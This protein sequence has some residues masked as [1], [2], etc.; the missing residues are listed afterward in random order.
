[1]FIFTVILAMSNSQDWPDAFFWITMISVVVINSKYFTPV[2][3]G[4][5]VKQ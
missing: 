5:K 3:P 2:V 1:M 4:I